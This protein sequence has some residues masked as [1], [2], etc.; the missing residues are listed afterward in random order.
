M[1]EPFDPETYLQQKRASAGGA[2]FD[3]D[4]YLEKKKSE[5][6]EP[7]LLETLAHQGLA[8][9]FKQGSDELTGQLSRLDP[10][11]QVHG[12]AVQLPDGSVRF[13]E[14]GDDT[15]AAGTEL[16]RQKLDRE[17]DAHP[18]ASMIA[19]AGG[20]LASDA[21]LKGL[22]PQLPVGSLPYQLISGAVSGA[23]GSTDETPGGR[24]GGAV[25]GGAAAAAGHGLGKYVAGPLIARGS[26]A[27]RSTMNAIPESVREYAAKRA[28]NAAGYIAKDIKP[29]ARKDPE[30]LIEKG[31][32]L[33]DE[34][35]VQPFSKAEST[36]ERAADAQ[37]RYGQ[38]IGATLQAAD[39]S[40]AKFSMKPFVTRARQT[41]L[42][43]IENDPA[44]ANEAAQL[45][46]LL[47]GYEKVGPVGF[48][49]A[50]QMKANLQQKI[51]WGNRWNDARADI[52][53]D[54]KIALQGIFLDEVD[55]QMGDTFSRMG[56]PG[57]RLRDAF[58]EIKRRYGILAE[59]SDKARQGL[60]R[61]EASNFKFADR[62]LGGA[63][64]GGGI[65]P[66]L[67]SG[68]PGMALGSL[69]LGGAAAIGNKL[70]RERGASTLAAGANKLA[71]VLQMA[72]GSRATQWL[73][74]VPTDALQQYAG[75]LV[76]AA[77]RGPQALATALYVMSQ[78][79]PK[80]RDLRKGAE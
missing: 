73:A 74:K 72:S 52:P 59:A 78:Q 10:R 35:V 4:V 58:K 76:S 26:A 63:V 32:Q 62:A 50:N 29:I 33:L 6:N 70:F 41:I 51:N 45:S 48:E 16:E 77:A 65:M 15:A 34:G 56:Q 66:A 19:N 40:G 49:E 79:D 13:L 23:L 80:F 71:D 28:L 53:N 60:A 1:P 12:A 68:N 2:A 24:A 31:Q 38:A 42:A 21:T 57:Q 67:I 39:S 5:G 54:I 30:L 75:P 43:P 25:L 44:M 18:I 22:I 11:T 55:N 3:P 9:F 7:G 36:A 17:F 14:S 69:A 61:D 46:A 20:E 37:A 64:A 47:D 27:A 8:G